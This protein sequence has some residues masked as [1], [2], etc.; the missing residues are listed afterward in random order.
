M[1]KIHRIV[2]FEIYYSIDYHILKLITRYAV[3]PPYFFSGKNTFM[4][5]FQCHM[6]VLYFLLGT[7]SEFMRLEGSWNRRLLTLQRGAT[8]TARPSK[9][10]TCSGAMSTA[11]RAALSH[12]FDYISTTQKENV[13]GLLCMC[14]RRSWINSDMLYMYTLM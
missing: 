7:S 9:N 14:S 3:P 2:L 8:S 10:V 12:S 6:L 13:M 5:L 4:M 1:V 11:C